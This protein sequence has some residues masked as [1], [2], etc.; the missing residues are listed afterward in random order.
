VKLR[1]LTAGLSLAGL[2]LPEA[3]AFAGIAGLSSG[4][5][6]A[7]TIAGTCVYALVGQSRFG[8]ISPTSSSAAI[9]AAALAATANPNR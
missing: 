7:A 2:M 8:I 3:V 5:A 9:L 4:R 6:I 1:D